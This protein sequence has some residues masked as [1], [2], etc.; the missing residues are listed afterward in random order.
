MSTIYK[1]ANG[2]YMGDSTGSLPRAMGV[3]KAIWR[4]IDDGSRTWFNCQ[5]GIPNANALRLTKSF[6]QQFVRS[7]ML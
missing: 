6:G 3:N 7:N 5:I 2:P 1:R 4:P